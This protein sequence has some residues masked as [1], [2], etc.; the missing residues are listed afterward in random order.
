M[1]N[2][3]IYV[4]EKDE[5]LFEEAKSIAGEALSSVISR[6]LREFIAR[7]TEKEKGMKEISVKVGKENAQQEKRF[8]GYSLGKWS[9]FS[10]DEVWWLEGQIYK[11]QKGSIAVLLQTVAKA[12]LLTNPTLWK[13]SGDYLINAKKSEF[14]VAKKAQQLKGKLPKDLLEIIENASQRDENPVEYLDI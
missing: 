4:S 10:D 11:T 7:N 8:T 12:T 13:A 3:T 9:G 14:F 6:A 1:P 5:N 2:K